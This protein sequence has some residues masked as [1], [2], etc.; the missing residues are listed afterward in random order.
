MTHQL[1][2][3]GSVP[4]KKNNWKPRKGG[5]I[6]L[7]TAVSHTIEG[8]KW[9]IAALW[10][11]KPPID[12]AAVRCTFY[13]RHERADADNMLTTILDALVKCRVLV[14][15]NIKHA[16]LGSYSAIPGHE[17][18]RVRIRIRALAPAPKKRKAVGAG[19]V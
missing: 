2:L 5:G 9:Q 15:D 14:N 4:A 3:T 10:Q 8:L 11:G 13:T 12:R 7:D 19:R 17:D 6:M 18:E 16:P 1:W